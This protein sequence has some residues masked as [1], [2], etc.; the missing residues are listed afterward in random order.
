[1]FM[2]KLK[3]KVS[4]FFRYQAKKA[5][6]IG[7]AILLLVV[8]FFVVR[9]VIEP[10]GSRSDV[11][12]NMP[13]ADMIY[14]FEYLMTALEE[15]WPFFNLSISANGVDVRNLAN[16][17]RTLLNDPA[18]DLNCPIDFF[19]IILEHFFEPINQLGNLWPTVSYE[20]FFTTRDRLR[21]EVQSQGANNRL[22]TYLYDLHTKPEVA[23][24]YNNLRSAG[25]GLPPPQAC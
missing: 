10:A 7:L 3:M 17:T 22:T 18:T 23:A 12:G 24:F 20:A 14:D 19:D 25:R 5:L 6:L 15:N 13:R 9:A 21:R 11:H 16:N 4:S 8:G 1:M 2:F